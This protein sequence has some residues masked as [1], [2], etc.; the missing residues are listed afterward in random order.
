MSQKK[1]N[2]HYFLELRQGLTYSRNRG[3]TESKGEYLAFIDDDVFVEVDYIENINQAFSNLK[4]A[5]LGGEIT[6]HYESGNPPVW[7]SKYLLPLVAA[8]DMGIH[9]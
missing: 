2:V 5:A 9:K 3:I 6:P 4:I 1:L 8:L 7:M